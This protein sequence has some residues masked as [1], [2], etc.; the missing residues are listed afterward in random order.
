MS[1]NT[2][3]KRPRGK[4]NR[5]APLQ[6]RIRVR[7][8]RLDQVDEDKISLAF[9]LLA[10]QLVED[11]SDGASADDKTPGNGSGDDETAGEAAT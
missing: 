8:R 2:N 1:S 3:N 10:K 11:Q 7:S 9:W 6:N 4:T 5:N